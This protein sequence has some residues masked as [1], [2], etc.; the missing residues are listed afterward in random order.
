MGGGVGVGDGGGVGVSDGGGRGSGG[1]N[2]GCH[3]LQEC[4][5]SLTL[6][7]LLRPPHALLSHNLGQ[8][9]DGP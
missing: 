3:N 2:P 5:V 1:G 9:K 8:R 7:T 4:V 6:C